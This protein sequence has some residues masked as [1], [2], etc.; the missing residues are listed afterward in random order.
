G[1]DQPTHPAT[2]NSVRS[3]VSFDLTATGATSHILRKTTAR[4]MDATGLT[5]REIA[6]Q[7]GHSGTSLAQDRYLGRKVA[8]TR[9]AAGRG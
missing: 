6:D 1:M 4:I 3:T 8:S 2:A 5:A 7:L 9:A